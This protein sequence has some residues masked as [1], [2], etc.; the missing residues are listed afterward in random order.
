MC[1]LNEHVFLIA[2][3]K[4]AR[5]VFFDGHGLFL[6]IEFNDNA[7]HFLIIKDQADV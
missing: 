6:I 5:S 7:K 2:G 1:S 3:H 4:V